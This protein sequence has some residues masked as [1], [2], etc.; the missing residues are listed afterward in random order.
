MVTKDVAT[1]VLQR[2]LETGADFAELFC[3][4]TVNGRIELV[5]GKVDKSTTRHIYGVGIRVLKDFQEVYGY[6]SDCSEK[7]LLALAA[8]LSAAYDGKPL[9]IQFELQETT[10]ET[11]H[12]KILRPSDSVPVEEKIS[13]L[14]TVDDAI[15]SVEGCIVQ[16]IVN[17]QE[18]TQRVTI[19][20]TKGKFV[21]DLRNQQRIAA[22]VV[23]SDGVKSQANSNSIGGNFDIDEYKKY[24]LATFGKEV[25]QTTLRMLTADEI[26][27]GVY[28]VIIHNGFGGVLFHEA[29]GHSLEATSVARGQS[30]FT[31]RLGEKIASD[32]VTAIDD[33]T[34]F[35][36]WGSTNIDDEGNRARRNVL[37]EK[38]VLKGYLIDDRNSRFMKMPSTGSGRR[39]SYRFS[40]TSRMTNTYI[41]NGEST[42]EDIIKNTKYGIFCKSMGGGSVNPVTGEFNFSVSEGYMVEDGKITRPVRGATL[43]G[44]GANA[45]LNIDMVANNRSFGYGV[46]GSR[47]GSIFACVGEPTIRIQ[48]MTV[49]GSGG[50]KQ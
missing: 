45:L 28:T 3:E 39:E 46:C 13:Y 35:N 26:E 37:I 21:H 40:P 29:C 6:T 1:K 30:V 2:C 49:G 42:F 41:E 31:G 10:T 34:I 20:N 33:G 8:K 17:M 43:I 27:G 22:R 47:S 7:G 23:A 18:H 36:E 16:R 38:G 19:A 25:A 5:G 9:G 15:A 12:V 44:N 11:D 48:N 24:D 14:R 4:D 50:K 32:V